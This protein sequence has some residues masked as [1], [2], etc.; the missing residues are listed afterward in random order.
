[1]LSQYS[2]LRSNNVELLLLVLELRTLDGASPQSSHC[3]Q[4]QRLFG[5]FTF[6]LKLFKMAM[7]MTGIKE[8]LHLSNLSL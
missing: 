8:L 4:L 1:M 6:R 2:S 3:H 7:Y 5:V